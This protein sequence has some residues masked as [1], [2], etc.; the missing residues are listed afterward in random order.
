MI[1][2]LE[3]IL[4]INIKILVYVNF[5]PSNVVYQTGLNSKWLKTV[6]T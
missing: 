4:R 2:F 1:R 3:G 5:A 6:K